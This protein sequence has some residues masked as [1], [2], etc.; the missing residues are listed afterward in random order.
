D[1]EIGPIKQDIQNTKDRIAQEV[2]D[3]QNAIQQAKDGLSQQIIDGDE[4]VLE[5]VETVKKSSDD[6]LAAA[7]ESIR[8][9]AN[10]LSL[11]AEKTDGVYAQLNPAL[12]GSESD[13]IGN[14]QGFAGTWSVQSAMIEGDLA[15][16]KRIDTTAV[17]LNNLQAYAQRDVQARIE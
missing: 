2:I 10:D 1:A 9:V 7:Q 17:E 5:V 15:L 8:V 16:S 3:R 13:L 12:I 14:D 6:G 11:V 4:S